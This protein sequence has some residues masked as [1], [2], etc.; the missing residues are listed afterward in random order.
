MKISSPVLLDL[1]GTLT[2][3]GP[4]IMRAAAHAL[5]AFGITET[6][7]ARLR[8]FVGP[9]LK[10]SFRQF[11][12]MDEADAIRGVEKYREYYADRGIFECTVYP[13]MPDLLA[14]LRQ[15]GR[16]LSLATSKPEFYARRILDHFGLAGYFDFV[17]GSLPDESRS[18]KSEV[19]GWAMA[20]LPGADPARA[21]MVGD[22]WYDVAGAHAVGVRCV[23]VLFGYGGREELAR[24][25]AEYLAADVPALRALFET[26]LLK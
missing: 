26:D 7:P 25:G 12:G 17:G 19:I 8:R 4:G 2:D 13:G 10:E 14:R 24:A 18:E 23:G 1:D 9:P 22:R 20:H 16:I 3:S 5:R 11:Y 15:Q 6:D 21:V